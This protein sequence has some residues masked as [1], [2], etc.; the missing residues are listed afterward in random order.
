MV[1][2]PSN[3]NLRLGGRILADQLR[4]QGVDTIFC[5][6]GESYLGLLDG[7]Y[8]HRD[9]I[10]VIVTRHEGGA[11][12][13]AD[14]YAKLTGRPG[15]CAVTRGPGATN[16]SN[17]IHTAFQDSTPMIV[18]IGQVARSAR[19]R[20]AFQEIEYRDMFAPMAKWVGEI[21][22]AERIPEYVSRAFHVAQSG[23]PGPVILALPEDILLEPALA[24]D[25]PR[26]VAARAAPPPAL[27]AR[28]RELLAAAERPMVI[29]G[30]ATWDAGAARRLQDFA[31][32]NDLP[33]AVS[34]RAQDRFDNRH[35]HYAGHAGIGFD[36]K[37]KARL[38]NSDLLIVAGARL[39]EMTT[40]GYTLLDIPSPRQTLIHVH[41]DPNEIGRVHA[42][43]LGIN[44][45]MP[46]FAACLASLEPVQ[47]GR[48]AAWRAEA[49]GEYLD[50]I[51]PTPMHGDV[52][53]AEVVA[54]LSQVLPDD[55]II[56]NGSGNNTVWLHRFFQYKAFGT[57]VAATSGSMGYG[58]P[59]AV[60]A[61]LVH[62]DRTVICVN[63]DGC[64]LML[65]QELATAVQYGS[66]PIIIVV[67]NSMLATIRMHQ[68]RRFSGRVIATELVNPDFPGLARAYGAHGERVRRT[69]EFPAAFE[70]ARVSGKPAVIEII[71]DPES[72]NPRETI[73][74][75]RQAARSA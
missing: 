41:P 61:G 8:D 53:L 11:A 35:D 22:S 67:N 49:H 26:A 4:I 37:L 43:A 16:A 68:E 40:Q 65:G 20:E 17:G 58:V 46:E 50:F 19:D 73:T 32:A 30:G 54:H 62:P 24:G 9:A 36:P 23:R 12:N 70:R 66:A 42:P 15:V 59:A 10:R 57:Q 51:R 25:A 5:V 71:V 2:M 44:A 1:T 45:G 72:L 75:L 56:A 3:S 27:M 60:A 29:A 47:P 74:D 34:F 69:D 14:A 52:N 31:E 38:Q 13:M 39:G 21:G 64:F 48:W 7:L 18:L 28:L 55:A 6:P 33:V 63:G